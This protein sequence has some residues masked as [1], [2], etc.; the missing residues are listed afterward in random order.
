MDDNT[1]HAI[2][3]NRQKHRLRRTAHVGIVD[4]TGDVVSPP[5][6]RALDLYAVRVENDIVKVDTSR[7]M[8]RASFSADQTTR[9]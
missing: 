5:A 1:L 4:I 9:S 3:V 7:R 8:T 2:A 6:P